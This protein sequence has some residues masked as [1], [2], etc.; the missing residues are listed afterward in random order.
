MPFQP[1]FWEDKFWVSLGERLWALFELAR[2]TLELVEGDDSE[3]YVRA[4]AVISK[5]LVEGIGEKFELEEPVV[6]ELTGAR[7]VTEYMRLLSSFSIGRD[8]AVTLAWTTRF[9]TAEY[10]FASFDFFSEKPENFDRWVALTGAEVFYEPPAI[11]RG[12]EIDLTIYHYPGYL[13]N[14]SIEASAEHA[15]E[16]RFRYRVRIVEAGGGRES[17]GALLAKIG[18]VAWATLHDMPGIL[19]V[20][21]ATDARSIYLERAATRIP[22][23]AQ[24]LYESMNIGSLGDSKPFFFVAEGVDR[25]G[26]VWMEYRCEPEKLGYPVPRKCSDAVYLIKGALVWRERLC[27]ETNLTLTKTEHRIEA[28][29]QGRINVLEMLRGLSPYIFLGLID[30]VKLGGKKFMLVSRS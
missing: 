14:P 24:E 19:S 1:R 20:F 8:E 23:E 16:G 10:A 9:I 2:A 21:R 13:D 28:S 18:L 17:I 15:G 26:R 12:G 30:V 3:P 29:E 5:K 25:D 22:S 27:L 7:L 11:F 6:G 4:A